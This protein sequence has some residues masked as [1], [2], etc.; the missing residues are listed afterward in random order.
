MSKK[1]NNNKKP[2]ISPEQR[3]AEKLRLYKIKQGQHKLKNRSSK[4]C[5]NICHPNWQKYNVYRRVSKAILEE[6]S[7]SG[8]FDAEM[9][10]SRRTTK[11]E[12]KQDSNQAT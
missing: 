7:K 10:I 2:T 4:N 9:E 5:L 12:N 1:I 8:D 6:W 11:Q 3:R